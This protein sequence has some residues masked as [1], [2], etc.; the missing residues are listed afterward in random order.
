MYE[1]AIV[2]S[3]GGGGAEPADF[4][5]VSA[6]AATVIKQRSTISGTTYIKIQS[7]RTGVR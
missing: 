2:I 4:N 5:T 1:I 3:R 6:Y 7:Q